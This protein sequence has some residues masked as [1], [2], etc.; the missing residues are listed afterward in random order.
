MLE[1]R[2]AHAEPHF[3]AVLLVRPPIPSHR[4]A[5]AA[6]PAP[7]RLRTVLPLVVR[8]EGAEV[9]QGLGS[10]V[11]YVVLAALRAAVARE[12]QERGRRFRAS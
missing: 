5:L 6:P 12:P 7:E 2:P 10:G 9:L 3:P 8:L 1:I 4:E 11:A